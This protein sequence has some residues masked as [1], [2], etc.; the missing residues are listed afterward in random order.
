MM[1]RI[2]II[3][4]NSK[5]TYPDLSIAYLV[6][7]L[8]AAGLQ[9]EVKTLT[10]ATPSEPPTNQRLKHNLSQPELNLTNI[11][12]YLEN[13]H[14]DLILI[15]SYLNHYATVQH[16]AN[17][18]ADLELPLILGGACLTSCSSEDLPLW[19]SLRGI[20]AVFVGEADWVIVDVVETLLRKQDLAVWPGI[21]Q[22]GLEL[23]T[24]SA[25]PL[26]DLELLPLPDLSDFAWQTHRSALI[27]ILT[28][29]TT[30]LENKQ[31][32]YSSRPVQSVLEELQIQA[33]RYQC[34]DFI[35][36]D[37]SLN[38]NLAMWHGLIDNIQAVVPGCRWLATIYLDGK[39]PLGL[40]LNTFVAARAAGLRHLNISLDTA[41]AL[42]QGKLLNAAM[43]RNRELVAHAYQAGLSV[44]CLVKNY[45][46]HNSLAELPNTNDLILRKLVE[47]EQAKQVA[48][49]QGK[50]VSSSKI[51][52]NSQPKQNS[53]KRTRQASV[54]TLSTPPAAPTAND[55]F[56]R[57][58][59]KTLVLPKARKTSEANQLV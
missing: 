28:G 2:L 53:A 39:N 56:W 16:L 54:K 40:D 4:L 36:L 32:V 25:P 46:T 22:S 10:T 33:E 13:T 5:L 21:C 30:R 18:A 31:Y 59:K 1:A 44:H 29:R 50:H 9:V 15:P 8:R 51:E 11:Q 12:K 7:P 47:N 38:T 57:R 48:S 49:L 58:F 27:P 34:K 20:T 3:N 26:Q 52:T 41:Q 23:E 55:N 42:R 24:F 14:P 19:L 37:T 45:T 6:T 43:E 17:Y 35:F